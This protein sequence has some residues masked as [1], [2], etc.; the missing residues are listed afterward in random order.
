MGYGAAYGDVI[1]QES[2]QELCPQEWAAFQDAM[3]ESGIE[4]FGVYSAERMGEEIPVE[5]KQAFDKLL[6]TFRM[7]TELSL[8]LN[9]HNSA[10]DGDRYDDVDGAFWE[11]EG[12]YQLTPA[13]QK[14]RNKVSRKFWVNFG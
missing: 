5:V 12:M 10:E 2:I 8:F 13:G 4:L 14:M 1:E 3:A 9:Y 6:N 7:V 11:V